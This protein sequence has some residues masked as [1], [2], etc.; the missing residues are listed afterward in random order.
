MNFMPMNLTIPILFGL[1]V[2]WLI[3]YLADVLPYTRR[4]SRPICQLCGAPYGW[5]N[6]AFFRPCKNGHTRKMRLWITQLVILAASVYTW[7]Q[8]PQPPLKLGYFPGLILMI[9]FGVVFVIDLEH[10]LILHPTS[11][12]GAILGLIIGIFANGVWPTLLGGLGGFLIMLA[13]YYLGVLFARIRAKRLLALGQEV[14]DEEALGSGDVILVT[15]LGL[16]LGK[17]LIWFCLLYGILLGG[18]VS[19]FILLWLI[20]SGRYKANALMTFIPYGPYFVTTAALIAFFPKF[21]AMVVP[22]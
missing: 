18:L 17:D 16:I 7:M 15:I 3:N 5:Q 22:D 12:F 21:L 1:F 2:G 20:V 14:D 6:Y 8:S 9:Y 13:F 19:L 11:I 4:F 10:R